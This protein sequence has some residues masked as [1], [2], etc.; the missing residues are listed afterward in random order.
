MSSACLGGA[1]SGSGSGGGGGDRPSQTPHG[2]NIPLDANEM[3][4]ALF[5]ELLESLNKGLSESSHAQNQAADQ[6]RGSL[7]FLVVVVVAAQRLESAA[8]SILRYGCCIFSLKITSVRALRC[9][10]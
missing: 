2:P 5:I 8:W 1:S 4:L 7:P 6:V 3:N 9:A 10:P